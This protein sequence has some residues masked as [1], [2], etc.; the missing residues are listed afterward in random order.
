[1]KC[2]IGKDICSQYWQ[3]D[4]GVGVAD[5]CNIRGHD[6][7]KND[8]FFHYCVHCGEALCTSRSWNNY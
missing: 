2:F 6:D 1:M 5:G 3:V 8:S 4:P 7:I